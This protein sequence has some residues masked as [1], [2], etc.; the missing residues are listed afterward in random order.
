MFP[1]PPPPR[2]THTHTQEND[3]EPHFGFFYVVLTVFPNDGRGNSCVFNEQ[4]L[5]NEL[6]TLDSAAN[7]FNPTVY[8]GKDRV[9]AVII[10]I[11]P[12]LSG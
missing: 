8:S 4:G 6:I 10:T 7:N 1:P 3:T 2:S 11:E 5:G 9:K 12:E